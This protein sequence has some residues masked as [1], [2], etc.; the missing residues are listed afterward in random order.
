[1][2]YMFSA[3]SISNWIDSVHILMDTLSFVIYFPNLNN[4]YSKIFAYLTFI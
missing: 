4:T 2:F 1:M 3:N